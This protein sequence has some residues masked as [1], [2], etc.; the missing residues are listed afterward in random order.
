MSLWAARPGWSWRARRRPATARH[1]SCLRGVATHLPPASSASVLPGVRGVRGATRPLLSGVTRPLA[2]GPSKRGSAASRSSAVSERVERV[3]A[4]PQRSSSA[5]ALCG[6]RP[7]VEATGRRRRH[8][9]EVGARASVSRHNVCRGKQTTSCVRFNGRTTLAGCAHHAHPRRR[10]AP[11]AHNVRPN[12]GAV[13]AIPGKL[14][15]QGLKAQPQA[16]RRRAPQAQERGH[17]M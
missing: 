17:V 7:P 13:S 6:C 11:A 9:W 14:W 10:L 4:A 8:R 3:S 2:A 16:L 1:P 15:A 5:Q 12:A